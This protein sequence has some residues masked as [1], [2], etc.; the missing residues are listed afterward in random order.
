MSNSVLRQQGEAM[1]RSTVQTSLQN[2]QKM[3]FS[4][5]TCSLQL[6][7]PPFVRVRYADCLLSPFKGGP[8]SLRTL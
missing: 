7:N 3:T 5:L 1:R 6:E 8:R 4:I 2:L